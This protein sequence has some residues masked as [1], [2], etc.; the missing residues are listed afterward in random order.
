MLRMARRRAG[1]SQR[2]LARR[3]GVPQ[4]TVSRIENGV[5]S[6]TVETL[7][8]LIQAC[9]MEL[10]VLEPAGVG[11]DRSLLAERLRMSPA[12]RATYAV[13]AVEGLKRLRRAVGLPEVVPQR[14]V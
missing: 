2:E 1:F 6:P 9:G 11:V 5:V 10:E 8:P 14:G 4:A 3:A 13:Q 7:E 12:E